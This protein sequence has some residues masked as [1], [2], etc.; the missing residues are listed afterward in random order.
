[1]NEN[2]PEVK[3][4]F[5]HLYWKGILTMRVS[6]LRIWMSVLLLVACS[7][8][9]M[10]YVHKGEKW[11][12]RG[13]NESWG[14]YYRE[15]RGADS[16]TFV[17]RKDGLGSDKN[18]IWSEEKHIDAD[19][20]TFKHIG[21]PFFRDK[22]NVFYIKGGISALIK[23]ADPT[24]FKFVDGEY[25][26]D[27]NTAYFQYNSISY[28]DVPTL[29]STND[30]HVTEKNAEMN[31]QIK[32]RKIKRTSKSLDETPLIIAE[33]RWNYCRKNHKSESEVKDC[34]G[35]MARKDFACLKKPSL[36]ESNNCIKEIYGTSSQR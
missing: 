23:K 32:F 25:G 24:S 10:G 31:R 19:V 29:T 1:M 21:G 36:S 20:S 16:P 6:S 15:L 30:Y 4:F 33:L 28:S 2:F 13:F 27:I 3:D 5:L 12:Y 22:N 18:G 8:C 14:I 34:A 9:N 11:Y 26:K 7:G 35:L 17:I